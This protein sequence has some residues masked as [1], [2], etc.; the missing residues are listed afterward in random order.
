M[1]SAV[2]G[3]P[4]RAG[5]MVLIWIAE[6]DVPEVMIIKPV[7][8]PS[9]SAVA[10]TSVNGVPDDQ[11]AVTSLGRSARIA[12]NILSAVMLLD[13]DAI[14]LLTTR[15]A[16]LIADVCAKAGEPGAGPAG[17]PGARTGT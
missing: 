5:I 3:V 14:I 6:L 7:I 8:L 2:S 15:L 10:G 17:V 16:T 9:E 4:P 12:A 11:F 13:G 1:P